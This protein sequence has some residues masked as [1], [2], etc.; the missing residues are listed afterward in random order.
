[1][2]QL[3]NTLIASIRFNHSE[4]NKRIQKAAEKYVKAASGMSQEDL[5]QA[6]KK[7]DL[8]LD[9]IKS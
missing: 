4:D 2:K 1:M 3:V 7:L 6:V 5:N 9:K 8:S